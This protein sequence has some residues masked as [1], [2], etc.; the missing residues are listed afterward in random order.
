MP[1]EELSLRKMVGDVAGMDVRAR[2]V[3]HSVGSVRGKKCDLKKKEEK[4]LTSQSS[5]QWFW[6]GKLGLFSQDCVPRSDVQQVVN[7]SSLTRG[8]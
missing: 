2:Q 5:S 4:I 3:F 7:T 8:L 6:T 1:D